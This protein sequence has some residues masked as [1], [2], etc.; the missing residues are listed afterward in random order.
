MANRERNI[1]IKFFVDADENEVI[2]KKVK[3]SG[4][5]KSEYLRKMAIEGYVLKQDL[6]SLRELTN[7]INKIGVNI[8]QITKHA[9]EMGVV[10]HTEIKEVNGKMADIWQ[11]LKSALLNQQ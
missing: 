10:A 4:L 8:N 3:A 2:K 6:T 5:N 11:L 9:N 1:Q 7:A